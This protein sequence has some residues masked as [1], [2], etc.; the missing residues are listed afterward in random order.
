MD[1]SDKTVGILWMGGKSQRFKDSTKQARR[2]KNKI[3]HPLYGKSLFLW[4]FENI[5]SVVN[6]I[7]LSFHSFDQYEHFKEF[8]ESSSITLP[9][10]GKIIDSTKI[11][12]K[13]PL[14]AQ[15]SALQKQRKHAKVITTSADM[16]FIPSS[17]FKF[18]LE[19]PAGVCTLQSSEKIIEPLVSAYSLRKCKITTKFLS[20]IPFGRGDDIHR[21]VEDLTLMT[22]PE[23]FPS[24][25]TPWNTN[26]NYKH[27]IDNLNRKKNYLFS[28]KSSSIQI[29]NLEKQVIRNPGNNPMS[30]SNYLGGLNLEI[31]HKDSL[32]EQ[33]EVFEGLT[34]T[35]SFF[36]AGRLAEFLALSVKDKNSQSDWFSRAAESYWNE[37]NFW[38]K[39]DS[40]FIAVHSLKDAVRRRMRKQLSG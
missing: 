22:V 26:I 4:V 35:R 10:Y 3:Y 37:T 28:E 36:C 30:L 27:D 13:G 5:F 40:P 7:L 16:P 25:D 15:L 17:L 29:E 11:K 12:S 38:I 6:D 9:H 20:N 24:I 33:L 19:E 2:N 8:N 31:F 32:S 18:L 23:D 39:K 14:Q 21:G 1:N 34:Q